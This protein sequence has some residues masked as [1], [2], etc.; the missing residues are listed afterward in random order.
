MCLAGP[1]EQPAM[2]GDLAQPVAGTF[3]TRPER[4][5]AV[6]RLRGSG[7]LASPGHVKG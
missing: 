2:G 7:K 3:S 6:N 4:T 5:R 1:S